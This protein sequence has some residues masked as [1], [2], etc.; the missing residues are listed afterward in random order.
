[1]KQKLTLEETI[2]ALNMTMPAQTGETP[3]PKNKPAYADVY[4]T[5]A[6]DER[7][8]LDIYLPKQVDGPAPVIV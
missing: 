4:Y 6:K 8:S 3:V 1:M 5:E 2:Q 7:Q